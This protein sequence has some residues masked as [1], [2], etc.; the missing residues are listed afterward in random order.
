VHDKYDRDSV[1]YADVTGGME[2]YE[3]KSD[4]LCCGKAG[5][6][7]LILAFWIFWID[8]MLSF[9]IVLG[10]PGVILKCLN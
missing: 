5:S 4:Y 1:V 10:F 9:Q 3:I 7:L 6:F 8:E 2:R